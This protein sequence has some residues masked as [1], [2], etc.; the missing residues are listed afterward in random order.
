MACVAAPIH[1]Y[2][3]RKQWTAFTADGGNDI[4]SA[5]ALS[6]E[7]LIPQLSGVYGNSPGHLKAITLQQYWDA[8]RE[9]KRY[10][11]DYL[12]YW[13]DVNPHVDFVLLPATAAAAFAPAKALYPGYTAVANVL[14]FTAAVVPV[15][16][17]DRYKDVASEG[18][19][20]RSGLEKQVL[21]QYDA[22]IFHGIPV[23]IQLLGHRMDEERVLA[24]AAE[25]S[26]CLKNVA[27][28]IGK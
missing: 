17:V 27:N 6:G 20:P 9:Q 13:H 11:A 15:T 25:V 8:Q 22:E 26:R 3:N 28:D 23:G 1:E 2:S 5:H 21:E 12:R 19:T 14:D 24:G 18:A 10:Q 4:F 16:V 7:P